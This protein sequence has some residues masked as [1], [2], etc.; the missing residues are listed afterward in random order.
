MNSSL[1]RKV[2]IALGSAIFI[3]A[4]MGALSYRW[5]I[6]SDESGWWV[7]HTHDVLENIQDLN[8]AMQSIES[9]SC[10]FALTGNES[11]LANYGPDV[12][13]AERD[14]EALRALTA[15]NPA[16]QIYLS[17]IATLTAERIR[18][19]DMIVNLRRSQ[20]D[21]CWKRGG[22]AGQ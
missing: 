18:H 20:G 9:E 22:R 13:R 14:V 15:D 1:D 5:I 17:S 12:S 19:A 3:L 2:W 7:R 11:D 16:Q 10:R 6:F 8:L 4:L 21:C